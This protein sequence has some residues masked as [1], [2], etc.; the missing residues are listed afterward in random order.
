MSLATRCSTCNTVFRVVQDQ[1]K[2]SEGWVRCGRCGAV[3]NALEGLFDL[4]PEPGA[5]TAAPPASPPPASPPASPPATSPPAASPP[6]GLAPYPAGPA[7]SADE[8]AAELAGTASSAIDEHPLP[9]M[10]REPYF[11]EAAEPALVATSTEGDATPASR[12]AE[13]DRIDFADARFNRALLEEAGIAIPD[14]ADSVPAT[15]D[16]EPKPAL[17]TPTPAF[18]RQAERDARWS[19]PGARWTLALLGLLLMVAL[20][21][22]ATLHYRDLIVTLF[23][24][25]RP[26][27]LA[28]CEVARCSIEPL[29]RI[30]DIVIESSSLNALPGNDA[31]RLSVVLRNRG[32]F[33]LAMPAIELTL[34]DA[35]GQML[36]RRIFTPSDFALATP[37]VLPA[38]SEAPLQLVLTTSGRRASGYTVEPFYP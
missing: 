9:A 10:H 32:V 34:T 29:R 4:E 16:V 31:V 13:E 20:A 28:A 17:H 1:L 15:S 11:S 22:Q 3:F 18:M 33:P 24:E 12:V 7:T 2:V 6:A 5:P 26:A 23:P 38:A 36:A 35:G 27:L 21:L 14:D 30:D 25:A 8:P 19:R 37:A